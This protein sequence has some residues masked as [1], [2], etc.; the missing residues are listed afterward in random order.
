M[1]IDYIDQAKLPFIL[2]WLDWNFYAYKASLLLS[3][4]FFVF[5]WYFTQGSHSV[6]GLTLSLFVGFCFWSVYCVVRYGYAVG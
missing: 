6:D 5:H 1:L 3:V 2:V 4:S